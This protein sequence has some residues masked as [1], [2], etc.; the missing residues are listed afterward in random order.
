MAGRMQRYLRAFCVRFRKR[1]QNEKDFREFARTWKN[2]QLSKPVRCVDTGEVF[3]SVKDAAEAL[4]IPH[5]HISGVCKG[6]RAT[7]YGHRFEYSSGI[8]STSLC[9]EC[10]NAYGGCSWT[11]I[12]ETGKVMFQP[13]E[14]WDAVETTI[15]LGGRRMDK[16]YKVI[17]CPEFLREQ[18]EK[19]C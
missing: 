19:G 10:A 18:K 3:A 17:S 11:G 14:G 4:G 15:S 16:S 8:I 9:W 13:V 1:L 12:D 2:T 5:A 6:T 7:T